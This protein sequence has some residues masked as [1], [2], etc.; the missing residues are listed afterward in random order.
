MTLRRPFPLA[1]LSAAVLAAVCALAAVEAADA[2]TT[3]DGYARAVGVVAVAGVS[4]AALLAPPAWTLTG[5][6]VLAIFS[7]HWELLGVPIGVDRLV[8]AIGIGSLLAREWRHRDGRLATRPIDWLLILAGLYALVSAALAGTLEDPQSRF[9]LLDRFGLIPFAL[10]FAAPFAFRT[11]RDRRVLLGALVALG[12]YLGLDALI[13]TT[14]PRDLIVP[15]YI[16]DPLEGIHFDRARGPFLDASAMGMA[17]YAGMIAASIALVRWRSIEARI[18]AVAVVALCGVGIVLTQ[19]RAV[20]LAAA[21]ATP[22]AL[23]CA[24]ETRRWFVPIALAGLALVV[25]ALAVIPGVRAEADKRADDKQPIWDRK[26]SN[27]AAVR[28]I[29]ERPVTGFGWGRFAT[30]SGPYYRQSQDYPLTGVRDLHNVYLSNAVEL[31]GPG[32]FIWLLALLAAI[33]GAIVRRG[34]PELKPWKL[35]LVAFAVASLISYATAPFSYVFP[36]LLLW[37][38]AGV[39]WGPRPEPEVGGNAGFRAGGRF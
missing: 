5:G 7:S 32:A 12:L 17:L 16:N 14:G 15:S 30:E 38:W 1:L 29:A 18:L 9:T 4:V 28:M 10:F 31:G 25:G 19:T 11:E 3:L 26:N 22:V 23:L 8:L 27:A 39:A 34:P 35:G 2:P 24:R 13:E 6:L 21:I 37:L 20:W 36:T 33:G